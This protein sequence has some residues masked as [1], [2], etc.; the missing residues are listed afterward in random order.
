MFGYSE[1]RPPLEGETNDNYDS[2]F[3]EKR[4]LN[5][6]VPCYGKQAAAL[7]VGLHLQQGQPADI[8]TELRLA[9]RFLAQDPLLVA[10]AKRG[11]DRKKLYDQ[12]YQ[13]VSDVIDE[14]A[15]QDQQMSA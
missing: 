14:E 6:C 7:A 11:Q 3:A 1:C 4:R 5:L 2:E 9:H 15:G 13:A 12:V 10:A 8:D